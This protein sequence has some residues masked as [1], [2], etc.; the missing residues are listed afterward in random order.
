MTRI[1]KLAI[2]ESDAKPLLAVVAFECVCEAHI[3]ED[4]V[5]EAD[6]LYQQIATLALCL[7]YCLI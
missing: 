7:H 1:I 6:G 5:S 3:C 2:R 4:S